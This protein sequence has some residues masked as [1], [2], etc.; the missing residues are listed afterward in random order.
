MAVEIV[1]GFKRPAVT[2]H[3]VESI[4]LVPSRGGVFEVF[5][6]DDLVFSKIKEGRHALPG[7]IISLLRESESL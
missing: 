2:R 4:S 6:D 3:G 1:E 7:E 5:A